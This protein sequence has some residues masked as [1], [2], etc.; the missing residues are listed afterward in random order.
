MA[1]LADMDSDGV[2]APALVILSATGTTFSYMDA[3]NRSNMNIDMSFLLGD[4]LE[5]PRRAAYYSST[6]YFGGYGTPAVTPF[7]ADPKPFFM[8]FTS[9]WPSC[10]TITNTD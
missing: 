4:L 9:E 10:F 1:I 6:F 7:V 3:T 8:K 2:F 5:G